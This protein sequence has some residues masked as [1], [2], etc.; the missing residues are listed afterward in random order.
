MPC[1]DSEMNI[2]KWK[3]HSSQKMGVGWMREG[4]MEW[5]LLGYESF[6]PMKVK[7][8]H[9]PWWRLGVQPALLPAA[10]KVPG[11]WGQWDFSEHG[12]PQPS[13]SSDSELQGLTVDGCIRL[14]LPFINIFNRPGSWKYWWHG[15]LVWLLTCWEQLSSSLFI[16]QSVCGIIFSLSPYRHPPQVLEENLHQLPIMS[17]PLHILHWSNHPG[18]GQTLFL[19]AG[20]REGRDGGLAASPIGVSGIF[21]IPLFS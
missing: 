11:Q 5:S 15:L 14:N 12:F 18:A 19:F 9:L 20:Q 17:F 8:T 4:K 7:C 21:C 13:A 3:C 10:A 6:V 1:F 2:R 16:F